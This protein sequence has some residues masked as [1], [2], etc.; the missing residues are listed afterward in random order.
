M[1]VPTK[2][3]D[4]TVLAL[5]DLLSQ[6]DNSPKL[7]KLVEIITDQVQLFEDVTYEVLIERLLDAAA[8]VQLDVYGRVVGG[9]ALS[10]GGRT[11]DAFREI[12]RV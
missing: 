12:I 8:G 10:R 6:F 2:I 1:S 5:D 7:R 4:H 9:L 11:D 3:A